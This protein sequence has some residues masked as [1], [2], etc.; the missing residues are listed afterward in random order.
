ME[1]YQQLQYSRCDKGAIDGPAVGAVFVKS[2]DFGEKDD[3]IM[4]RLIFP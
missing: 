3:S 2:G 4:P 1:V